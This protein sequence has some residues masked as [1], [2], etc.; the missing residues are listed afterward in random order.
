MSDGVLEVAECWR[1]RRGGRKALKDE[2]STKEDR[3]RE[4]KESNGEVNGRNQMSAS[5]SVNALKW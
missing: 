3:G 1:R 5:L 4:K 2:N